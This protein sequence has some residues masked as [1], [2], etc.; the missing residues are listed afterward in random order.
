[1]LITA[2][3]EEPSVLQGSLYFWEITG[4]QGCARQ[5]QVHPVVNG[6]GN[7]IESIKSAHYIFSIKRMLCVIVTASMPAQWKINSFLIWR[8]GKQQHDADM[9]AMLLISAILSQKSG[10]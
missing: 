5:Q 6:G 2:G 3:L 4:F 10:L 8:S 1:M 7:R 9:Q